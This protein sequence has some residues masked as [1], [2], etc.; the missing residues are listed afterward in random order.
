MM[1]TS[2][3]VVVVVSL[4]AAEAAAQ[5][6][7]ASLDLASEAGLHFDLGIAAYGRGDFTAALEH[8][9]L[10]NRLAPNRNVLFNI[11]RCFE[12]L[13]R[14][15]DAWRYYAEYLGAETDP[16]ARVEAAEAEARL[17]LRV[18]LLRV[19]TDPPGATIYVDRRELGAVGI[20][21]R[22][23][24]VPAGVHRVSVELDGYRRAESEEVVVETGG[25]A[26]V[27]LVLSRIVGSVRVEGEPAGA[28]VRVDQEGGPVVGT[29]PATLEL[30]P[31]PHVLFVSSPD[32]TT[33]TRVVTAAAGVESRISVALERETGSLVLD[34]EET[35][36]VVELDGRPVGLTPLTLDRIPT[37]THRVRVSLEGLVPW[38]EEVTVRAGEPVVLQA[39]LRLSREVQAASRTP[40]LPENA[41]ASVTLIGRDEIRA[42]GYQTVY[43]ALSGV[44]GIYPS[45]DRTY[46]ALGFRGFARPGDYGNRVLTLLDGHVM[47]DDQVGASY[48]GRDFLGDLWDVQ[49]IEVVRGPGSTVYGSNAF[50]GVVNLVTRERGA[51]LP[52]HVALSAEQVRL[53]HVRAGGGYEFN[54]DAG[55][56]LSGSG[57]YSQGEDLYFPEFAYNELGGWARDVDGL[58]AGGAALRGWYEDFALKFSYNM[59]RRHY[60]TAGYETLFGDE[61]SWVEDQRGYVELSWEPQLGELV[62]L[63]LRTTV[64]WSQFRGQYPYDEDDG[65]VLT[66]AWDG[67]WTVS[68]ARVR[69]SLPWWQLRATL[70]GEARVHFNAHLYSRMELDPEG[71][72]YLDEEPTFQVY[73]AYAVVDATPLDWMSFSAGARFDYYRMPGFPTPSDYAVSPRASLVFRPSDADSLKLFGGS[74]F[75]A[76][77]PYEFF[78]NDG[79]V[80][81]LQAGDLEAETIY[82]GELEYTHRFTDELSLT[83]AGYFNQIEGLIDL[84]EQPPGPGGELLVRYENVPGHVRTV[85]AEVEFR[86]EWR[87]GWMVAASY[88][89]QRTRLDD[90]TSD[91]DADGNDLR[92]ENSPEH[93]FV[94]KAAAPLVPRLA[95]LATQL[96]VESPRWASLADGVETDVAVLWDVMLTGQAVDDHLEYGFGVRNLLDWEYGH[97]GGLSLPMYAVPQPGRTVFATAAWLF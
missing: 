33:A 52:P 15:D 39:R 57:T 25:E 55:L 45:D 9:F 46:P 44:R 73:S 72:Y 49:Q 7:A 81:Q 14:Y 80:T 4:F 19:V 54:E 32:W 94:L 82:T 50:F 74:A 16:E 92:I 78:Y 13:G 10:S 70:G 96:R 30:V 97:P 24:A 42:F 69:L 27:E 88:A 18:A 93:L 84:V 5:S 31:G 47:N 28:E 77:S 23:L 48:V 65:G 20:S 3:L 68:E 6:R 89:F 41:P 29:L 37:G 83:L 67:I 76:P 79:G 58:H 66:D 1:R 71:E 36:A 64:D 90:L 11:A 53:G 2:R 60:P 86:R 85:G 51:V 95:T 91:F 35:G 8:L 59:R 34:A 87:Q 40:E 22:T 62:G 12:Q 26:A 56:W 43:E 38:E 17:R 61:R 75:R 63:L 21:P